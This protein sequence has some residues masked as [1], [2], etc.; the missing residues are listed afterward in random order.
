D[1]NHD[2]HRGATAAEYGL[3]QTAVPV[4]PT[5]VGEFEIA[6][7]SLTNPP[8]LEVLG[9]LLSQLTT[10]RRDP[11]PERQVLAAIRTATGIPVALLNQQI[12]TLRRRLNATGD[13]RQQPIRPPW[14]GQLRLDLAGIPERNEANVITALANDEAFA[15]ALVFD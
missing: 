5:T 1:F 8:D 9:R 10:A 13:L 14:A 11:L 4:A 6:V 12:G 7:R 3:R 2:L 15:G